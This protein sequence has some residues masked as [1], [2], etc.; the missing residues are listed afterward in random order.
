M[1]YQLSNCDTC[2]KCNYCIDSE[3]CYDCNFCYNCANCNNCFMCSNLVNKQNHICN[4]PYS[5]EDYE[6]EVANLKAE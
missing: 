4:K 1:S 5:K 3:K 2:V 6:K